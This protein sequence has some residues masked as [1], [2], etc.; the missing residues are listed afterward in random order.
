MY[1]GCHLCTSMLEYID[2]SVDI[3]QE[4]HRTLMDYD[5]HAKTLMSVLSSELISSRRYINNSF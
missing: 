2:G 4:V 3:Y 5:G 1:S